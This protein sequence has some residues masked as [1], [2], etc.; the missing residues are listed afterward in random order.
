MP[1]P[2]NCK[3]LCQ[4]YTEAMPPVLIIKKLNYQNNKFK[5]FQL[6]KE[7]MLIKYKIIN[8]FQPAIVLVDI[9]NQESEV[10]LGLIFSQK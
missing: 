3:I 9:L 2:T 5:K 10:K 8:K 4:N 1:S 6:I 7:E